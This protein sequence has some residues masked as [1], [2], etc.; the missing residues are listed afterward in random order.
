MK[1][2]VSRH[3]SGVFVL[4]VRGPLTVERVEAAIAET[5]QTPGF[6]RR[7]HTVWDLREADLA[8][9]PVEDL[10]RVVAINA[11]FGDQRAGARSALRVARDVDYGIVR[12]FQVF[13]EKLPQTFRVFRAPEE[14]IAWAAAGDEEG[15]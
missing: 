2:D 5:R 11:R 8:D 1:L 7:S 4:R 3:P 6:H 9:A 12:M 14:A 10:R 15:G 13:A